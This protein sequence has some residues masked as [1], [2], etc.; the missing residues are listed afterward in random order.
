[1]STTWVEI[2]VDLPPEE[3]ERAALRL[4]ELGLPGWETDAAGP[5]LRLRVWA[6][7]EDA[8]TIAGALAALPGAAPPRARTLDRPAWA[9]QWPAERVGPFVIVTLGAPRPPLDPGEHLVVLPPALAFGGGEHPTTRL[10]LEALT[11][12][13]RPG[14]S[15]LDVGSGS[16]ILSVAS[17]RLGA[18]RIVATDVDPTARRATGRAAAASGVPVDVVDPLEAVGGP[19]DVVVANILGPVLVA[20]APELRAR[21]APGGAL[22]LS[23]V[24]AGAATPVLDAF[25]PL[26]LTAERAAGGWLALVLRAPEAGRAA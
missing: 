20:L 17:A 15:L 16:G 1:V 7:P 13:V 23:G 21:L 2:E 5:R 25:A 8:A 3:E 14:T 12:L 11:E 26:T 22:L 18:G 6:L 19:F 4:D 24:R 9:Q 10:C